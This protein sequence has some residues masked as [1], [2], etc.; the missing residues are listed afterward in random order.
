M[1]RPLRVEFDNSLY[2]ITARGDRRGRIFRS[3]SDR[4]TWLSILGETCDRF[5]FAVQAYCQMTNHYHILLETINGQIARGMCHLNGKYSRYFNRAHNLVGHVFQGRYK[6][7]ICQSD[8]Y[9]Q[10]LSRYIELNPVRARIAPM[11]G[12]WPWSSYGAKMGSIDSPAWL[13]SKKVLEQFGHDSAGAQEAYRKF[14]LAGIGGTSPLAAVSNQ[15]VLGDEKFQ[16][17]VIGARVA[18][19]PLELRRVH[20]RAVARP[21]SEYFREFH[22]PKEAMAQ[23]Y[24]SLAYSMSEIAQFARVSVKT[25]SR[26]VHA[27]KIAS[28][29]P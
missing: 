6:A 8:L 15:L 3:D 19:N 17:S 20:R 11:P 26:A 21:L 28:T 9:L 12:D 7:I 25:V 5:N 10:E 14:V 18:G 22:D 27:R 2:H 24:F 13:H 29:S 16:S 1:N 4:L 23:A